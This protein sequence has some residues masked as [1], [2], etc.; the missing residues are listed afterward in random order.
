M[1]TQDPQPTEEP[2]QRDD[3]PEAQ[4]S[5]HLGEEYGNESGVTVVHQRHNEAPKLPVTY[6]FIVIIGLVYLWSSWPSFE[7]STL[8]SRVL[9]AVFPKL[10]AEGQWYRIITANLMHGDW[11]HLMNNAFGLYIFGMLLEPS[12]GKNRTIT[13]YI[14]TGIGGMLASYFIDPVVTL[15]ASAI[16]FGLIGCYFTLVLLV[17][18]I[19]DPDNFGQQVKAALIWGAIFI[20]WN[21]MNQHEVNMVAHTGGLVIGAMYGVYLFST[22]PKHG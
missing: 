13:L 14:I 10:V 1:E 11:Y 8:D 20:G 12:L 5:D 6:T 15:G 18:R 16:N 3:T 19:N 17:E 21:W 9:A 22:R 2:T 7:K 4:F